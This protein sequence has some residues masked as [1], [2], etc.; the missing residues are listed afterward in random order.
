MFQLSV[1]LQGIAARTARGQASSAN[2]KVVG[3]FFKPL[4]GL[5]METIT[6]SKAEGKL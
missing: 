1:I 4:A 5:A 3:T 6:K 2:A